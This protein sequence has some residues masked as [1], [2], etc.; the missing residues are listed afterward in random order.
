M[1][2]N[3]L[4]YLTFLLPLALVLTVDLSMLALVIAK[5]Y[6]IK[7]RPKMFGQA[8]GWF[9]LALLLG[10]NLSFLLVLVLTLPSSFRDFSLLDCRRDLGA[11]S[12]GQ[13][14]RPKRGRGRH[15]RRSQLAPGRP[16]LR[17]PRPPQ[18]EVPLQ[19]QARA[20]HQ[21]LPHT[22]ALQVRR[23]TLGV[24]FLKQSKQVRET[25]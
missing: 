23:R 17:V 19:G 4:F 12:P 8:R 22:F 6:R 1:R 2:P 10:N 14:S 21:G 15:L 11:G 16:H 18:P 25:L 20:Q 5:V 7:P 3:L 24:L 13:V 9:S